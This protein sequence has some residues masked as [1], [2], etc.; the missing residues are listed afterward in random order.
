MRTFLSQ[1]R[2]IVCNGVVPVALVVTAT[3]ASAEEGGWYAGVAVDRSSISVLHGANMYYAPWESGP[4]SSGYTLR[5]GLRVNK[6]VAV[7]LGFQ[8]KRDLKWTEPFATVSDV[9][10]L[11]DSHVAFDAAVQQVSALG[12]WPFARVWEAYVKGG[13]ASYRFTGE[14]TLTDVISGTALLSRAVSTSGH[15]YVLGFGVGATFGQNWHASI[16][17]SGFD[18]DESFLGAAGAHASLGSWSLGLEY[19]VGRRSERP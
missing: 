13:L 3:A 8:Q 18:F 14:Q 5:G 4:S 15:N 6:H 11:F 19:R 12:V 7:E 10:G 17:V 2:R 1:M 9:P 16:D